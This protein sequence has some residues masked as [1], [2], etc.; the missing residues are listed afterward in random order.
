MTGALVVHLEITVAAVGEDLRAA[1]PEVGEPG[2]ELLGRRGGRLMKA[3]R[4]QD[5]LLDR[6]L[7]SLPWSC[8]GGLVASA[9][10]PVLARVNTGETSGRPAC[11]RDGEP[12]S[13][14]DRQIERGVVAEL[15]GERLLWGSVPV[16]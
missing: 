15:D 4:G 14:Q 9:Y 11:W 3:D 16:E 2:Q 5:V 12:A 13:C 1:R 6:D 7:C 8:P 10:T